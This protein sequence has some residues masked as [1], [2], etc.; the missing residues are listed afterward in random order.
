MQ[1]G[2]IRHRGPGV[3]E[4]TWEVSRDENG[5]H[6]QSETV[7]GT[8]AEARAQLDQRIAEVQLQR[9]EAKKAGK[10]KRLTKDWLRKWHATKVVPTLKTTTQERYLSAIEL[11]LIPDIGD[12][13]LAELAPRHVEELHQTLLDLDYHP[14]TIQ[15]I[16]TVL[17]GALKHANTLD[18]LQR[19]VAA[20]VP[21]PKAPK[22]EI[23]PPE[24]EQVM[25][26]LRLAEEEDHYLFLFLH[27][28]VYTGLRRG[29]AMALRWRYVDF[30][31][32]CLRVRASVVKSHH[33]G[34]ILESPK[35]ANGKRDIYL[36]DRT[37]ALL[38]GHREAQELDR[39][40]A[41]QEAGTKTRDWV[42]LDDNG[43]WLRPSNMLRDLK[44]LGCRAGIANLTFHQIR[45]FHATFLLEHLD[46]EFGTSRQMGHSS[47]STTA[48]L[49]GHPTKR[50]QKTISE[51]FGRAMD[52]EVID[53]EK[54][55]GAEDLPPI[56]PPDSN[57]AGSD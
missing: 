16:H 36:L 56:F 10:E 50:R 12:I 8:R 26:L 19:N 44:K 23:Q 37:L 27:V 47:V 14:H 42:F 18:I 6:R 5:R 15:L 55:E 4:I 30:L 46:D 21:A 53:T 3:E 11:Q 25:E 24:Y 33:Q 34:L 20:V 2:S 39:C 31:E 49:Y 17:S 54:Y 51:A 41:A 22:K 1:K 57:P 9:V 43:N 7:Y 28:L 29:E 48:N 45:H 32:R 35:T 13:P 52:G 40:G 38:A